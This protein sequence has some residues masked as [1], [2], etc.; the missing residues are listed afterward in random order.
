M[1]APR[2]ADRVVAEWFSTRDRSLAPQLQAVQAAVFLEDTF[3]IT[4]P[5]DV[6]DAEHLGDLDGMRRELGQHLQ[7]W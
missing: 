2:A 7:E 1:T 4:I 3:G 6:I 5:D